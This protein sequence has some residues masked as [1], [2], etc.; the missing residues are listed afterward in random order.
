MDLLDRMIGHDR[1]ATEKML[2]QSLELSD[3]QLDQGFDIGLR[4]IRETL[5]HIIYVIDLWT[6]EMKGEQVV[7]DRRS[8]DYDRSIASLRER[9]QRF[10]TEFASVA[11]QAQTDSRL[12][13]MFRDH[14]DFPQSIGATILQVL[15][16]NAQHRS[17]IRHMLVRLGVPQELDYD[18][19]EWEHLTGHISRSS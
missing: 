13:E 1:W 11:R 5:D 16:H 15:F 3:A 4:S 8:R 9:H 6:A 18:P 10:Q 17:E 7:H 19:Q 12:D 2:K 14:F